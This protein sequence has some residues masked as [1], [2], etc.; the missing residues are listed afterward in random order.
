MNH[1]ISRKLTPT[2][3]Y[4]LQLI[5]SKLSVSLRAKARKA[6]K[7]FDN[8]AVV[9]NLSQRFKIPEKNLRKILA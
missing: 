2:A 1:E 6:K 3:V 5:G 9:T 8:S 4:K 7:K